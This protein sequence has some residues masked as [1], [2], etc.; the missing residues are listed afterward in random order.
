M[1]FIRRCILF[2]SISISMK[3]VSAQ[4][5]LARRRMVS[6]LM[7]RV[8]AAGEIDVAQP[9]AVFLHHDQVGGGGK[10]RRGPTASDSTISAWRPAL[11]AQ[12]LGGVDQPHLG[13]EQRCRALAHALAPAGE[14]ALVVGEEIGI[15]GDCAP[16]A[17]SGSSTTPTTR[18]KRSSSTTSTGALRVGTGLRNFR[19]RRF[20]IELERLQHAARSCCRCRSAPSTR[21][22]ARASKCFLTSA[23]TASGTSMSRVMVSA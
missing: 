5:M 18:R 15:G 3:A 17:W 7:P 14:I 11:R 6:T 10:L 8:C 20:E 12:L 13:R 23:K 19:S 22:S 21:R 4:A 9:R 2:A 1:R 16:S